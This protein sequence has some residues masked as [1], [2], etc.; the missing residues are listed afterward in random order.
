MQK[1]ACEA[2]C[3]LSGRFF[4]KLFQK[5]FIYFVNT[6]EM[7]FQG[8][9]PNPT[10]G[11]GPFEPGLLIKRD[12]GIPTPFRKLRK[13]PSLKKAAPENFYYFLSNA[14]REI[15]SQSFAALLRRKENGSRQGKQTGCEHDALGLRVW[16]RRDVLSSAGAG[17][18]G[19]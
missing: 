7:A 10:K 6:D 12:E 14:Y 18:N 11:R 3:K 13:T 15:P 19:L 16:S 8:F 17:W 9:A 4:L 2:S 5:A 1:S